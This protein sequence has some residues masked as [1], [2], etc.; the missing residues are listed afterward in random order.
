[1]VVFAAKRCSAD[2]DLMTCGPFREYLPGGRVVRATE[3]QDRKR[4]AA[5]AI[6]ESEM[7]RKGRRIGQHSVR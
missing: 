3:D 7:G 5:G 6:I 4:T 1:M 2:M